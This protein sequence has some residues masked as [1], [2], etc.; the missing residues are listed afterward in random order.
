MKTDYAKYSKQELIGE[1]ENLKKRK[2]YGLVWN[3]EKTKEIF[4]QEALNKLP[5]LKEIT[6]KYIRGG[7]VESKTN[8]NVLIEGDNHHAL[9]VLNYT[10]K[11][12]IDVIYIDP[13]YNTGAS[14]W[15]YN[16]D[17]VDSEDPYKHSKWLSFMSKRLKLAKQLLKNNGVICCTIDDH[18]LFSL[19]GLF[20]KLN[21]K[22]LGIVTIVIKPEGR[23]QEKYFMTAHEY[24]IFVT[25]GN[26][27]LRKI[28]LRHQIKQ[29]FPETS[30]D[31][32][33]F[34]WSGLYRRGEIDSPRTSNR[35]YPIYVSKNNEISIVKKKNWNKVF[36]IDSNNVD[37]IWDWK[38]ER[39]DEILNTNKDEIRAKR[40]K[41]NNI[42]RIVIEHK[43]Y[44]SEKSKPL[45][46]WNHSEYSPQAYGN[47]LLQSI[48][49]TGKREFDF[50]KSIYAVY[51]CLDIFLPKKGLA[52][53]FFAGSGTTGHAILQ[54]NKEDGGNRKFI[55]C[56]NNENNICTDVCYP[57][58]KKVIKG[59]KNSKGKKIDG[60]GGN[61]KYFKTSFIASESTDHN[62]KAIVDQ[63]TEMLCLKEDCFELIKKN[64]KFKI[65]RGFGD[66]HFG[67]IYYYD[68][69]DPF[70]KEIL[71]LNQKINTY[72]F[73][74]NDIVDENDFESI[75]HLVNLKPIPSAILNV[76][77]RIFTNV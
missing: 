17:Y 53:D 71:K 8:S 58:V 63:S 50:P 66:K 23:N 34:R 11:G 20:E 22:I 5:I 54:L 47:K 69:I 64:K 37:K 7:G 77:R 46:Y 48:L 10:H 55:L 12:K 65:F 18:E 30:E 49:N 68:G 44:K 14:D 19:L 4:E 29:K 59:Y 26:P 16:N 35:W 52:L 73:S 74:L 36:P 38:K 31:G 76:Y 28:T 56:T 61:F 51:D 13:P 42:E 1:I 33:K 21:A 72:V 75:D 32:R 70:K 67:I 6:S 62:K 15:R 9:S 24:A 25:W 57:R 27:T 45:S 2:K 39:L 3:E 40:T 41:K 60:L 43:F